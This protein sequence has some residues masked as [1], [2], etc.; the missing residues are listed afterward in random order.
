MVLGQVV[1]VDRTVH[2]VVGVVQQGIKRNLVLGL[3]VR[4]LED[5]VV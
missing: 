3:T 2:L 5:M 1:L 4:K